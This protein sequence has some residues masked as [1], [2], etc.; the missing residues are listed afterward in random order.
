MELVGKIFE[1]LE[2]NQLALVQLA[3]VVVLAFLLSVLLI[4]PILRTF[5]ERE[6]LSVKPVEESRRMLAEAEEK[7]RRYDES[8]RKSSLEA[9][10][11]KRGIMEEQSR[12]ERKRVEAAVEES[13]KKIEQIK[14]KILAEKEAAS[15]SLRAQVT[16]LSR[17]IAEKVLGRKVA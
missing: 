7:A 11:R 6:N 5:E 17:E 8:F 2:I 12:A 3:L 10:A 15:S 9:L 13:N 1:T 4:R 14:G 16:L